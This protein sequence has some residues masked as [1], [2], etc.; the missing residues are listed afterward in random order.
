MII[1]KAKQ[2]SEAGQMAEEALIAEM[3]K[4]REE[5][6]AAGVLRDASGLS[7]APKGGILDPMRKPRAF[8]SSWP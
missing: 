2:D 7:P 3:A 8:S 1:V 4:Y 6:A 5:P